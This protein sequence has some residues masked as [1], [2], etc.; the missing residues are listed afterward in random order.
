MYILLKVEVK[1]V[2][3]AKREEKVAGWRAQKKMTR[4]RRQKK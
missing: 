3:G 1:A 4:T 2:N